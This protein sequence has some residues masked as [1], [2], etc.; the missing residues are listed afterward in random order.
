MPGAISNHKER[1]PQ[2]PSGK[3]CHIPM[4]AAMSEAKYLAARPKK[5]AKRAFLCRETDQIRPFTLYN[6]GYAGELK[7]LTSLR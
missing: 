4:S 1:P 2:D 7:I 3:H 5:K 6:T